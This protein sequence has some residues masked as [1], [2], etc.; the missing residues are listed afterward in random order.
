LLVNRG[1]C[2]AERVERSCARSVENPKH[3]EVFVAAGLDAPR[4]PASR[5][6]Q[7][8]PKPATG[9]EECPAAE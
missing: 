5:P 3:G 2:C 6:L 1:I 9:L 7:P 8:V 4:V